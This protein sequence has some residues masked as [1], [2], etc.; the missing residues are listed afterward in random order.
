MNSSRRIMVGGLLIASVAL[1]AAPGRSGGFPQGSSVRAERAEQ[2]ST[3]QVILVDRTVKAVKYEHRSGSTKI[4]FDGTDL[5]SGAKGEAKVDS[6]RGAL[7]IK[8]EFW[9]MD[10]PTT[11]G[12][13]YLTYVMW[14]ISPEGRQVNLGE[15]LIGG[16]HRSKLDVTTDLQA[17]ALIVTAE[18]YYAVRRPSNVVV[19]ENAVRSDTAGSIEVVDAKYE[20]V[21]R[22]GYI[23]TGYKFDPVVLNARLPLEFFEARNALRI[24]QSA[25]AERYATTSYDNAAEQMKQADDM[26]GHKGT[27]QKRLSATSRLV[28][29]TAEDAREISVKRIEA[30][31]AEAR[32]TADANRLTS[33]RAETRSAEAEAADANRG[34]VAAA[35]GQAR[36]EQDTAD[37]NR[38][39]ADA[40]RQNR[41]AQDSARN[42]AAGQVQAEQDTADA[43]RGRADAERQNRDAQD[44]ARN[45]AA[46]QVRAEQD[47]AD[48]RQQQHDAQAESDRNKAAAV[49]SD[50][51]LQQ[52]L[53][54]REELRARLLVQ[55]NAILETQD[56]A[57]GLVVN[58]SDVLFDT[59]KFTLRPLAREKLA[60]IS[61]IILL[62]PSLAMAIEGNTDS[63]GGDAYN[64]Q[65]S[66]DRA[67]SVRDYLA[68]EGVPAASMSAHG[69]GKTHPVASNDTADG[70][71]RNRRVELVVSGAVIGNDAG[72]GPAAGNL[73]LTAR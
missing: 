65:L 1:L 8:V 9:N 2:E 40:E 36:A 64:Q 32:T 59:A 30:D 47:T 18:P 10:K 48:A 37:A 17:F 49:N 67:G 62:Y 27:D 69:F 45:A 34:R 44:S 23:P 3:Y 22:G 7:E 26:A 20:L 53:R 15:V 4:N 41:D 12:P 19:V 50:E 21:D 63:V 52:A 29:Q 31:L 38:G 61:G 66:E 14:A 71:Q 42:A 46:G 39:R 13:E 51:Q 6:H 68:Q 16:N 43:N 24:A 28:V 25:G 11:F 72:L 5:M 57:R 33:S 54:E 56:T 35:A 60:K 73:P 70:R 58:M 55:F